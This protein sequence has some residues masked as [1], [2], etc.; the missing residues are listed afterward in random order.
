MKKLYTLFITLFISAASFGQTTLTPGDIII[1][2]LRTDTPKEFRFVTLVDLDPGTEIYF[3][4]SG[5]NGTS[6]RASEG[7]LKYTAPS[8][9]SAGTNIGYTGT[10]AEIG[11]NPNFSIYTD[12]VG[13]NGFNLSMSGDQVIVFQGSGTSP[14]FIFAIQSNSTVW[15]V[16]SDDAN[17]SDLP[18]GLTAGT[19]ALALGVDAGAESEFDNIY[20]TGAISG[21]K[22]AILLAIANPTNWQ[23]DN[24]NSNIITTDFTLAT[25][26]V[27]KNQIA[28]FSMYPNPVV[29]GKILISSNN[30]AAKQVAIYNLVGQ[31]VYNKSVI[32]NEPINVTSLTKGMY[33]LKVEEEGK[34]ATRKLLIN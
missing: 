28:G 1:I 19:N 14:T 3:T 13:N 29:H 22:A 21:T 32:A 15:Q 31:Q 2:G 17:Q 18:T 12:G 24:T 11:D 9:I 27:E 26:S 20:Y 8:L 25:A 30:S 10:N 6:F 7:G 23:G 16:G 4:D 34:I 33:I 5:W